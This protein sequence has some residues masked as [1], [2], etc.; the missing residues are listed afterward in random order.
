MLFII[1][2]SPNDENIY[3]SLSHYNFSL[4]NPR[5]GKRAGWGVRNR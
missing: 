5:G 4:L 3:P 1:A 2:K